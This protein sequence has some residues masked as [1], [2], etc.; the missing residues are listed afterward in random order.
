M[1]TFNYIFTLLGYGKK[2]KMPTHP[3]KTQKFY[4]RGTKTKDVNSTKAGQPLC[5]MLAIAYKM[6]PSKV[7]KPLSALFYEMNILQSLQT[8]Q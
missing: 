8:L 7:L 5:T 3:Y 6:A 2:N 4:T 1:S